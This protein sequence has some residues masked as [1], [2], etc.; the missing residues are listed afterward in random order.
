MFLG[1]DSTDSVQGGCTTHVAVETWR[2]LA[3]YGVRGGPRLVRLNPNVPYKTR[4]NGALCL[5]LGHGIGR[6]RLAGVIRGVEVWAYPR[7]EQPTHKEQEEIFRVAKD[8]VDTL[9]SP[10]SNTGLVA[11]AAPPPEST[12][13]GAVRRHVAMPNIDAGTVTATWGTGRGRLGALAACAWPAERGSYE[14]IA[15]REPSRWGTRRSV[16]LQTGAELDARAPRSFDNWD[17]VHEHLRVTPS[18]PCPIFAGIRGTNAAELPTALSVLDSEPVDSWAV[19]VTNQASGDHLVPRPLDALEPFDATITRAHVSGQPR[20]VGGGHVFLPIEEN[21]IRATVAA[22]EPTKDLRHA[23]RALCEGD[24]ILVEAAVHEDTRTLAAE[25]IQLLDAVPRTQ[26]VA[27]CACGGS[28]PSKGRR[29][30]RHC[31]RC[32]ERIERL[33][34]GRALPS[35]DRVTVPTAVRRHLATPP[36]FTDARLVLPF[37]GIAA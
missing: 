18:S 10:D 1:L 22:F 26:T 34:S 33:P 6:K 32:G 20:N 37:G 35:L 3:A 17:P 29:A 9:R 15:Y 7:I 12:Y 5:E 36:G 24:E 4:G 16:P 8:A 21:G 19:F 14:L 25:A 30:A 23:V 27:A 31:L 13:N 2:R 28:A 11:S